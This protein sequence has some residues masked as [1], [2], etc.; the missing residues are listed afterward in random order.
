MH[1]AASEKENLARWN[2]ILIWMGISFFFTGLGFT[3]GSSISVFL[4]AK[5]YRGKVL[6][7]LVF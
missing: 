6:Y 3:L 7:L 2:N 4:R 1:L 5:K